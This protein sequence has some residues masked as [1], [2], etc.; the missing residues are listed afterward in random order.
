MPNCKRVT[1]SGAVY[2]IEYYPISETVRDF[3]NSKPEPVNVRTDAEKERYNKHKSEKHFIRLVNTNFTSAAYYVTLTYDNEHLPESYAA[4][5][6]NLDKY[7]R[8]LRYSNPNAKIIA[9]TGYGRKS[10]RL[11]H[12]LIV[13]GVSEGDILGKWTF[14][15]IAKVEHLRKNNYYNGVNHGEDYTALAVYLHRHTPA[16][17]KGKR[18]KQTKTIQQPLREKAE[19]VKRVYSPE[20]P[21][22]APNGFELVEVKTC[23][24]FNGYI[25]FKYVRKPCEPLNIQPNFSKRKRHSESQRL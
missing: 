7:I 23:E 25:N 11:H 24:W 2:E 21:S 22:K 5:V 17:H 18:W 4:A 13:S 3:K 10:G 16:D 1:R 14:G 6:K 8:R 19:R 15:E 12:H 20:R 9:V